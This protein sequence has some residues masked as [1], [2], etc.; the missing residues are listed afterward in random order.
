MN[1]KKDYLWALMSFTYPAF[2][3]A[4]SAIAI[5]II[6]HLFNFRKFKTVYFSN[7]RFLKEVKQETQAKSKLKHLLVLFSRILA[8]TFLVF[9]FAQPFI[10]AI[11]KKTVAGDKAISIFIDN[12]FSMDAINKNGTLL[13]E[14]KKHAREIVSAYKPADRFQL[15]TND[16]EGRHQR[17]VNKEEF[18]EL[19]DEIKISPA[20][21]SF[22]DITSR[23]FDL[24]HQS[25]SKSKNIFILSDFQKGMYDPQALKNDTSIIIKLIPLIAAQKNNVYIDSCWFETPVR[26]YNQLEK[27]HIRIKNR[28]DKTLENNSIR[29]FINNNQKTPASFNIESNSETEVIL[30]F[31]SKETGTQHCRIELNDYPVTFDD[32]FYFSFDVAKN[33]PVLSINSPAAESPYLN[34][35]LGSDSLFIYTNSFENQIDYSTLSTFKLIVLNELKSISSGLAQELKRFMDNGGSLLIF[36]SAD[37]DLNTY[38]EFLIAAGTAYFEK[39]DTI[40]T[41]VEK[42]NLESEIYKDV[43]DKKTFSATNLDLPIASEHYSVSR[44]TRSNEEYLMKLQNGDI[45]LSKYT[46]GK[47]KLYLCAVALSSSFSNFTKHAVF[48][49]TLYKIAMHSQA[50]QP[51]FYTIGNNQS[52]ETTSVLTGESVYHIKAT[53]SDFDVIPEHKTINSKTEIIPHNQIKD[54]GNYNLLADKNIVLGIS[55]NYHRHESDL[56]CYSTKELKEILLKSGYNNISLLEGGEQNISESLRELE[57]GKKLWKLC[58]ILALLFLAI[59]VLLLRLMKG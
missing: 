48:V 11:N 15:L 37:A 6:I 43:F 29:L 22:S 44:I 41:K 19:L 24:L 23:Q 27:L 32:K 58:I 59:E 10:P 7:T 34:K 20:T 31:A 9:A 14:A 25:S 40:N 53:D 5:P 56:S 4:L 26:Q 50:A 57:Q 1:F 28:S 3:F 52:I 42:I 51:L 38:K 47:G 30:S 55:W 49:P 18:N 45:F 16:F 33:I 8:I 35:L 54:A 21:K 2:L 39:R 17:L 13:D 46:V 12:S 36:P